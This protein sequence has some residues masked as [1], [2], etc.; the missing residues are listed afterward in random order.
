[1]DHCCR[2]GHGDMADIIVFGSDPAGRRYYRT[3]L[4]GRPRIPPCAGLGA[5]TVT[6]VENSVIWSPLVSIAPAIRDG[7]DRFSG[8]DPKNVALATDGG[9][10]PGRG[11]EARRRRARRRRGRGAGPGGLIARQSHT[12]A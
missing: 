11:Q 7:L 1:M 4:A 8:I 9:S 6:L 2:V 3:R 10:S 5:S 12:G